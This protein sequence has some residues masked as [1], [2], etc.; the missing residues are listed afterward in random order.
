MNII[1]LT[2]EYAQNMSV[3]IINAKKDYHLKGISMLIYAKPKT[4]KTTFISTLPGKV[5][6][7]DF[8]KGWSVLR[9]CE[10]VDIIRVGKNM[11]NWGEVWD[12][13]EQVIDNYDFICL[14]SIT[15]MYKS[16]LYYFADIGKMK[17]KPEQGQ[18][19]EAYIKLAKIMRQFRDYTDAGKNIIS[20]ALE[21]QI[22]EEQDDLSLITS[23][24]PLLPEKMTAEIEALFDVIARMEIQP[25]NGTDASFRWLRL[26]RDPKIMAGNRI[27]DKKSCL[28]T[29]SAFITN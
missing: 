14:D 7:I 20:I 3:E 4:G 9:E 22:K 17:G 6:L 1:H 25:A 5:L 11:T 28:A 16:M 21:Q 26:D 29:W 18:Y 8:E 2:Q 19:Q 13:I 15:D 12:T 24:H 10:N 23:T 27:N